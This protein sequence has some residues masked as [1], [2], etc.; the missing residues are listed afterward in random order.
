MLWLCQ[1]DQESSPI[2]PSLSA[3]TFSQWNPTLALLPST[4]LPHDDETALK[5]Q[6]WLSLSSLL[7]FPCPSNVVR[8]YCFSFSC[9]FFPSLLFFI[10]IMFVKLSFCFVLVKRGFFTFME[11][12]KE[13][14]IWY[15]LNTTDWS[16]NYTGWL[17]FR[18]Q[19]TLTFSSFT[20]NI[21]FPFYIAK[22]YK[23]LLKKV[24]GNLE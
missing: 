17:L 8:D 18:D 4:P 7:S 3:V 10:F 24:C 15:F 6:Y 13:G 12:R 21:S 22:L 2:F 14:T 5:A 1:K 11:A 16:Q 20:D 19:I 9:T 23:R